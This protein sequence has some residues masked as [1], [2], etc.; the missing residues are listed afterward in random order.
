ML[1]EDKFDWVGLGASLL[2]LIHCLIVP[3][4]MIWNNELDLHSMPMWD[5]MSV[6]FA[7][8]SFWAI[9]HVTQ[10]TNIKWLKAAFWVS[11]IFLLVGIFAHHSL[12]GEILNYSAATLLIGFHTY[13]IAKGNHKLV[14]NH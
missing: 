5:L 11:F 4:A 6:G 12:I 2:C 14:H 10:H 13:N 8:L 1:K 7:I 3:I 9:W